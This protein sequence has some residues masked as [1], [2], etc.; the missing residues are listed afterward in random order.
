MRVTGRA[1][2]AGSSSAGVPKAALAEAVA[3]LENVLRV[4]LQGNFF[5]VEELRDIVLAVFAA[6]EPVRTATD[7]RPWQTFDPRRMARQTVVDAVDQALAA[8]DAARMKTV[9]DYAEYVAEAV[10]ALGD[11][12]S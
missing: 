12:D 2:S 5:E 10:K 11:E 6:A 3:A 9:A 1:S 4:K 7:G 8:A